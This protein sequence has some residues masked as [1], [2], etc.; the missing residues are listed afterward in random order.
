M[1]DCFFDSPVAFL[2]SIAVGAALI[3]ITAAFFVGSIDGKVRES[4]NLH[5]PLI[6]DAD[7]GD[8]ASSKASDDEKI[9]L[10]E[11]SRCRLNTHTHIRFL[12]RFESA[13]S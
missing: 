13:R 1:Y 4:D 7:K 5:T 11:L 2:Y 10:G 8:R 9:S 6:A 3:D 12:P